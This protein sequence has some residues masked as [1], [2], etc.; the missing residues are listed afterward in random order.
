L[1]SMAV[2]SDSSGVNLLDHGI[3]E[4]SYWIFRNIPDSRTDDFV[5]KI[6]CVRDNG[7]IGFRPLT[8]NGTPFYS[9]LLSGLD[10]ER[11]VKLVE[12]RHLVK[13]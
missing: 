1:H 7:K 9:L 10:T 11:F 5:I 12:Q 8:D 4:G 3:V 13:I 2:S 6:N